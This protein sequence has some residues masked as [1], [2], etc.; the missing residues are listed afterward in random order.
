MRHVIAVYH[1][2]DDIQGPIEKPVSSLR[3]IADFV[4][5]ETQRSILE[6]T[7]L[8]AIEEWTS[9]DTSFHV[10]FVVMDREW[11][12]FHVEDIVMLVSQDFNVPVERLASI[13]PLLE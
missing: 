12:E 3:D 5:K 10:Y 4:F 6:D 1:C 8:F 9:G 13:T 2:D 7:D 11:F